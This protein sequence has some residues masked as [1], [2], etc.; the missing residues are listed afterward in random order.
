MTP[1]PAS[2]VATLHEIPHRAPSWVKMGNKLPGLL[3]GFA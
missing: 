1:T 2:A 3:Q